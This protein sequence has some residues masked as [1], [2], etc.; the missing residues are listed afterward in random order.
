MCKRVK[1]SRRTKHPEFLIDT[2]AFQGVSDGF[3]LVQELV[4]KKLRREQL[5]AEQLT[6]EPSAAKAAESL[7]ERYSRLEIVIAGWIDHAVLQFHSRLQGDI[8]SLPKMLRELDSYRPDQGGDVCFYLA[9]LGYNEVLATMISFENM[10]VSTARYRR[11]CV[12]AYAKS[13]LCVTLIES[14][15]TLSGDLTVGAAPDWSWFR[16]DSPQCGNRHRRSND[17]T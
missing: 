8:R 1:N 3:E 11:T 7:F 2:A 13:V 5:L 15:R 16:I 17:D 14:W 10:T 6:C 4:T 9:D 12:K